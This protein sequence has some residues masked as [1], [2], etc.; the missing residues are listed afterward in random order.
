MSTASAFEKVKFMKQRTK[1]IVFGYIRNG[2]ALLPH[3]NPY[4]NVNQLI[5]YLCCLYFNNMIDSKILSD[6]D[7]E[8]F[9]SLLKKYNKFDN[10][11]NQ[12]HW[13]LVY[14]GTDDGFNE[15]RMI[16]NIY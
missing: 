6:E 1:D 4:Y 9:L 15:D 11:N 2:Q 8:L 16:N 12:Y 10:L 14:R 3:D 7:E 5:K 13:N